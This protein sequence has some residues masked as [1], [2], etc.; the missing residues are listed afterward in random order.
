MTLLKDLFQ[1]A[2]KTPTFDAKKI[3]YKLRIKVHQKYGATPIQT[4]HHICGEKER[5]KKRKNVTR[6]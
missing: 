5:E 3:K 2:Y 6:L 1:E 4:Q